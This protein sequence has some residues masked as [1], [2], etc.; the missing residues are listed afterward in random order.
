MPTIYY[1]AVFDRAEDGRLG[2]VFPD[3]PGCVS[4][5]ATEQ[6]AAANAAEALAFHAEGMAEDGDAL[7]P[8]SALH[9]PLPDWL[10]EAGEEVGRALIPLAVASERVPAP[11]VAVVLD[12]ATLARLDAAAAAE[13][14][15][16]TEYVAGALRERLAAASAGAGAE[17]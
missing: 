2:V 5:G 7:P 1:P 9:A 14:R 8:P 16:R 3:L 6:E 10:A 17:A 13:G 4:F 11:L 12:A 15:S